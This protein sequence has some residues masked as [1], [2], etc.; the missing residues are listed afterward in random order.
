MLKEFIFYVLLIWGIPSTS[1]RSRFRK[2]VYQ[3]NDWRI[4]IKPLFIKEIKALVTNLYP[5]D[6][7]Y[8]RMRKWYAIYLLIYVLLF[9]FYMCLPDSSAS[10][11]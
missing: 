8:K 2:K 5:D 6:T 4:N 3:T 7:T 9:V 11:V 1:M 10:V